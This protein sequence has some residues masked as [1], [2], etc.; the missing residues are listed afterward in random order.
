MCH[1]LQTGLPKQ[2]DWEYA[3]AQIKSSTTSWRVCFTS[4][5]VT[6]QKNIINVFWRRIKTLNK[7]LL[8]KR[9]TSKQNLY[10]PQTNQGWILRHTSGINSPF[11]LAKIMLVKKFEEPLTLSPKEHSLPASSFLNACYFDKQNKGFQA[12]WGVNAAEVLLG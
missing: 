10:W 4:C 7:I 3:K 2:W 9:R 1:S 12:P 8:L 11:C 6:P 5:Y